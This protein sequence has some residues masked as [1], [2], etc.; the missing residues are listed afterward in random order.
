VGI[1]TAVATVVFALL[2]LWL[3]DR[4]LSLTR[5]DLYVRLPTAEGLK[6]GDPVFFRGVSV[7]EVRSLDFGEDGGVIVRSR[8]KRRVPLRADAKAAL[9][10]VDIFGSQSVVLTGGTAAAPL[11]ADGDTIA[12]EPPSS[13]AGPIESLGAHAELVGTRVARLLGDTTIQLVHGTLAGASGAAAGLQGL[14]GDA[15]VLLAAQSANLTATTANA[16]ALTA[17]LSRATR[18]EELSL[19]IANLEQATANLAA[20]T[21]SMSHASASLASALDKVNNGHG[22]AGRLL[23]DPVLFERAF[24]A[25]AR[26]ETLLQDVQENPKRYVSFSLF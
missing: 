6:K 10:A 24:A 17:N 22:T 8:L 15:H 12:G 5:S 2:F 4:G 3:T 13:L 26:L 1:L 19:A 21:S 23:N 20:M 16:A 7:G 9:A 25:T 18:G 14:L 11:L